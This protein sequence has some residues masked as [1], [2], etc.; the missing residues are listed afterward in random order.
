MKK[1]RPTKTGTLRISHSSSS[2]FLIGES[3]LIS[4]EASRMQSFT[5][6]FKYQCGENRVLL[7]QVTFTRLVDY[8]FVTVVFNVAQTF[9]FC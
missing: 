3:A 1:T 7:S 9:Y 4:D 2:H 5:G 6:S 8:E